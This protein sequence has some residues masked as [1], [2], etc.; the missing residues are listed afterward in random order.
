LE[1]AIEKKKNKSNYTCK[2]EWLETTIELLHGFDLEE[3]LGHTVYH[4]TSDKRAF[5]AYL[6]LH[7]MMREEKILVPYVLY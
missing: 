6:A 1:R 4:D 5:H 3:S 7:F 2:W